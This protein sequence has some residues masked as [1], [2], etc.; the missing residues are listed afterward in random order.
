MQF[1]D[2]SSLGRAIASD[3]VQII[4]ITHNL[5]TF[6]NSRSAMQS[7]SLDVVRSDRQGCIA[8]LFAEHQ[9][10]GPSRPRL[11][12]PALFDLGRE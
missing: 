9:R 12:G 6:A 2:E 8:R 3:S 4:T 1:V 5:L 7:N 11:R 10:P